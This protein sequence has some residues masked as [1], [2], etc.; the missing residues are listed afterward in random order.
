MGKGEPDSCSVGA[1]LR[2]E[3]TTQPVAR[4]VDLQLRLAMQSMSLARFEDPYHVGMVPPKFAHSN[5]DMPRSIGNS[6]PV[7]M[8]GE[9][10]LQAAEYFL[11]SLSTSKNL[12]KKAH[13]QTV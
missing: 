3:P 9:V 13:R 12:K 11:P 7:H 6:Y 5:T 10:F 4:Y 8:M 1:I 2:E